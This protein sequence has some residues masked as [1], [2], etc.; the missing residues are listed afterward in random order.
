M[1]MQRFFEFF[2]RKTYGALWNNLFNFFH[3]AKH[4]KKI[5]SSF[6]VFYWTTILFK[7]YFIDYYLFMTKFKEKVRTISPF[8]GGWGEEKQPKILPPASSKAGGDWF[9]ISHK[10]YFVW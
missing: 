10:F 6:G 8:G 9:W 7:L 2:R 1:A 3:L 5:T 4:I